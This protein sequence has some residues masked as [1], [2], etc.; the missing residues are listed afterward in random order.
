MLRYA[1]EY[2]EIFRLTVGSL[3]ALNAG[4]AEPKKVLLF[5]LLRLTDL[6]GVFPVITTCSCCGARVERPQLWSSREGGTVCPACAETRAVT[7]SQPEVLRCLAH[8]GRGQLSDLP[9]EQ[10]G[11]EAVAGT[12]RQ[13][14]DYL[15]EQYDLHLRTGRLLP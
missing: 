13:L 14:L 10:A 3:G 15:R 2:E 6:L 1:A 9:D 5:F 8:F 12:C 11:R 4:T 7:R